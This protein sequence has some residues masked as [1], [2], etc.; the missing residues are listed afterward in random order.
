MEKIGFIGGADKSNLIMYIAKLLDDIGKRVLV[1]DATMF[2][3]MRYIVPAINPTRAYITN[4]EN[5]DFAIGFVSM[6]ELKSYLGN[7][8]EFEDEENAPYDYILLDL[9]SK[10]AIE[11]F[12]IDESEQNYFVTTFDMYALQKS[13]EIL[14]RLPTTMKLSKILLNF[15]MRKDDEEYLLFITTDTKVIWD[16]KFTI[17]MPIMDENE[18]VIQDSQRVHKLSIKKLIPEYQEGII[19]IVQ[20]IVKDLPANKIRKMIKN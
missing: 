2:Q 5:I 19:Y 8:I 14:K 7:E 3:R 10:V 11:N 12:E 20:N 6:S 15:N 13:V 9:D 1:I 16:D 4:Y 18:K 17:Y